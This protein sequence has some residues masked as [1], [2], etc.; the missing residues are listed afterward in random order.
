MQMKTSLNLNLFKLKRKSK[1]GKAKNTNPINCVA[2]RRHLFKITWKFL[3]KVILFHFIEQWHLN[4]KLILMFPYQITRRVSMDI[5]LK[6]TLRRKLMKAFFVVVFTFPS[7]TS[8][9]QSKY[10]CSAT[11]EINFLFFLLL[12]RLFLLSR[13]I[14]SQ[15]L[16]QH[17]KRCMIFTCYRST[18]ATR[19]QFGNI[20]KSCGIFSY[21]IVPHTTHYIIFYV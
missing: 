5:L 9:Q 16:A 20:T 15:I 10:R 19:L 3:S 14:Q 1:A 21:R 11:W 4:L 17:Y 12:P 2:F 7:I 8:E 13:K 6:S 18:L